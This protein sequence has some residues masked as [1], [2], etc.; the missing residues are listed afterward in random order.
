MAI[1]MQHREDENTA[2]VKW[3]LLCLTP[4]LNPSTYS[5]HGI[6]LLLH[7]WVLLCGLPSVWR[8]TFI[9]LTMNQRN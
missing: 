5:P 7:F 4:P 3:F 1:T 2:N 6:F 9:R 8:G